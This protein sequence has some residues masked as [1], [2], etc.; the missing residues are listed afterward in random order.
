MDIE[1]KI[2]S[3]HADEVIFGLL[4]EIYAETKANQALLKTLLLVNNQDPNARRIIDEQIEK[5]ASEAKEDLATIIFAKYAHID[6]DKFNSES[7]NDKG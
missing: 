5:V 6:I 1:F 2:L 4:V 3:E 7:K